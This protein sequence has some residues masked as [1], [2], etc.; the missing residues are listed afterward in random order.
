MTNA[1]ESG[2]YRVLDRHLRCSASD[3]VVEAALVAVLASPGLEVERALGLAWPQRKEALLRH[4]CIGH[5]SLHLARG[6]KAKRESSRGGSLGC[7]LPARLSALLSVVGHCTR[8]R[9]RGGGGRKV[10]LG[11]K[12]VGGG[13]PSRDCCHG[14]EE[15][16]DAVRAHMRFPE[17]GA[18]RWGVVRRHRCAESWGSALGGCTHMRR[19]VE[20]AL[21]PKLA[22]ARLHEKAT[23]GLARAHG[24]HAVRVAVVRDRGARCVL[25]RTVDL[26]ALLG[27][28]SFA[29]NRMVV[30]AKEGLGFRV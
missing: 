22:G 20:L 25:D 18:G 29:V 16:W 27:D 28:S 24:G 2:T 17:A 19:V 5:G 23:V 13:V 7:H 4:D 8:K 3:W 6:V 12:Q 14:V 1:R 10:L 9:R 21:L 30:P 15:V 26:S 11:G